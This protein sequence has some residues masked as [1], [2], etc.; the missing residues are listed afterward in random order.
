MDARFAIRV[1]A[2]APLVMET[3]LGFDLQALPAVRVIFR[4]RELLMRARAPHRVPRG[5]LDELTG[6][7]WGLLHYDAGGLVVGGAACRPW[8]A[9]VV[10]QPLEAENC[11]AHATPGQVKIV[12]SLEAEPGGPAVTWFRNE[13]RVGSAEPD[14]RQKFLRYWRWARF[15]IIA[16]RLLL[17]PA[18]RREAERRHRL[19]GRGAPP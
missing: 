1:R 11:A 7:G 4:M 6:L 8:E 9:D 13:T 19:G 18:V 16:I 3:A 12:W 10:F 2:P 15:G 17:L 14:V 5:L